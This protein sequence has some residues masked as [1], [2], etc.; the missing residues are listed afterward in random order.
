MKRKFILFISSILLCFSSQAQN[1]KLV[2]RYDDFTLQSDSLNEGVISAF[3]KQHIPLVLGVIPFD[4]KE[5]LILENNYPF[6]S[7]L[8]LSVQDKSVEIALHG[9]NHQKLAD[10]E[11]GN[12]NKE[13]QYRRINK[14]KSILDSIFQTNIVTFIPPWNAYDGNTL[15]ILEQTGI[16]VIS[17]SLT[18]NQPFSNHNISYFPHSI[19]DL[20]LLIPVLEHNKNRNGV[21]VVMFHAY[22]FNKTYSLAKLESLLTYINGMKQV[23]CVSFQQLYNASEKSDKKRML[24]NMESNLLYKYLHL[25]GVIQTTTYAYVIRI[26]NVLLYLA[27]CF[28]IYFLSFRLV[29]R[30]DRFWKRNFYM[31][32]TVLIIV[33]AFSVWFQLLAPL[34]LLLVFTVLSVLWPLLLKIVKK[35]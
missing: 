25:K 6:F 22:D 21:V 4:T 24:A 13:E 33:I 30:K 15:D 28:F 1:I 23:K 12:V 26:L 16:K 14:G 10:G 17:S 19:G 20:N 8:K 2:F 32:G 11:F 7:R 27:W 35:K 34:K 9:F 3:Q 29:G 5:K 31:L 18:I